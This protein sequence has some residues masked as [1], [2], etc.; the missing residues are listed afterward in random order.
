MAG[1]EVALV[2]ERGG[3]TIVLPPLPSHDQGHEREW[4]LSPCS[5]P[6]LSL[7][8]QLY[9]IDIMVYSAS[10]A[11]WYTTIKSSS[12]Q[13]CP[14]ITQ[15]VMCYLHIDTSLSLSPFH[16]RERCYSLSQYCTLIMLHPPRIL[17]QANPANNLYI[18]GVGSYGP[19][20]QCGEY[21]VG[22]GNWTVLERLIDSL[23]QGK[24]LKPVNHWV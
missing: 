9:D 15:T 3:E 19:C 23:D 4:E 10:E 11:V 7:T 6:S 12:K 14:V 1:T 20:Q 21:M 5:V 22:D 18:S 24:P 17:D 8:S 13:I 16:S 2:H